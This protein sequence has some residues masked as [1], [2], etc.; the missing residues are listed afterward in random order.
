MRSEKIVG[1]KRQA[2]QEKMKR[3]A[4]AFPYIYDLYSLGVTEALEWV[5]GQ[6]K[7]L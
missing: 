2:Y 5:L 6:R 7:E 1:R 3:Q 4:I